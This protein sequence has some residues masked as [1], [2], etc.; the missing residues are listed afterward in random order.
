MFA[1][2]LGI[3]AAVKARISDHLWAMV[4]RGAKSITEDINWRKAAGILCAYNQRGV[5]VMMCIGGNWKGW[6]EGWG[7]SVHVGLKN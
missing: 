5:C 3:C 1:C 7:R 2:P 6:G 4:R